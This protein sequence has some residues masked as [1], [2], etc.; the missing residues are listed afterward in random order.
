MGD[1]EW[2]TGEG[3]GAVGG[4]LGGAAARGAVRVAEAVGGGVGQRIAWVS[5]SD[6]SNRA[7]VAVI[8]CPS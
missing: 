3:D 2:G 8:R 1:G 7:R 5:W 6:G 4:G